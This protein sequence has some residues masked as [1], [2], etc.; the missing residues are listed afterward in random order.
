MILG[1]SGKFPVITKLLL[2]LY[3]ICAGYPKIVGIAIIASTGLCNDGFSM[4]K[5]A[6]ILDSPHNPHI[7]IIRY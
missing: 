1:R 7:D 2:Q 3:I 4:W 6:A 5:Y